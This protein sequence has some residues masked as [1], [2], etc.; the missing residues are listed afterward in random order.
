MKKLIYRPEIDGL[1]AVAVIAVI[2]YHTRI[3]ILGQD[4]FKGGFIGVD[5]FLVISGYLITSLILKELQTTGKFSFLFFYQR[6]ARR[7]LPVLFFIMLVSLPFAWKYLLPTDYVDFSKS[8]LYSIGFS[9]NFYFHFTGLEYGALEG[10]LKPFLHTWSL[11][12]EEQ[13]YIIFP[14]ILLT[15]YKFFKNNLL[16]FLLILSLVSLCLANW[17]TINNPSASFYFLH[18]RMWELLAGSILA[19]LEI[20]NKKRWSF[21]NKLINQLILIFGLILIIHSIVF[22]EDNFF[23]P[24]IYTLSP[25]IGVCLI[26]WFANK[27]EIITKIFSSKLF[28]GTG[29]ISYS[30][31]LWHYPA[32]AL[33]RYSLASGSLLKKILIIIFIIVASI[34]TYFFIE[35]PF[36]NRKKMSVKNLI[37]FLLLLL[38]PLI[39][40][41]I[42]VIKNNGFDNRYVFDKINLDN[43]F[44]L[45]ERQEYNKNIKISSF[46]KDNKKKVLVIGNSHGQDL[47]NILKL[48]EELFE[49]YEF[50]R[51]GVEINCLESFFINK[52]LCNHK[53]NKIHLNNFLMSDIIVLST[54]WRD[55]DKEKIN[56]ILVNL[57]ESGKKIVLTTAAP[58]FKTFGRFTIIDKFIL[59]NERLPNKNEIIKFKKIYYESYINNQSVN[60]LNKFLKSLAIKHNLKIL[61]KDLYL[62]DH[63]KNICEFFTNKGEKINFDRDHYT[64][65]GAKYLGKKIHRI[66]WF[67]LN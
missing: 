2:L 50:S 1:R 21:S 54:R 18:T 45:K 64:I 42:Y 57:K 36:R 24:S 3:T 4:F 65:A 67:K 12:V 27:D 39:L 66:N 25:V 29:L 34:L 6:R 44:Y 20:K 22:F 7:I 40:V 38:T 11:S 46:K 52:T 48:N 28:V 30:L 37:W 62:C 5:I 61:D 10:L 59:S 14:I 58:E 8:I 55:L 31:Y 60:S 17:T 43:R 13:F 63:K 16:F 51:I 56:K 35:K 49:E 53:I 32:F 23:H 33:F 26:I 47:F 19:Y 41:N 15:F 9:S